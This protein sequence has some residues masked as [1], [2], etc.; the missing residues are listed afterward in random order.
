MQKA[1]FGM[2]KA[3]RLLWARLMIKPVLTPPFLMMKQK[4][5]AEALVPLCWP[6]PD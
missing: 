3:C 2:V 1:G 6:Y 4:V 5:Q